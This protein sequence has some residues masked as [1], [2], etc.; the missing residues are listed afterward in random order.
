M[1]VTCSLLHISS[2]PQK[3]FSTKILSVGDIDIN[4]KLDKTLTGKTQYLPYS[5]SFI[6]G[7][8]C[9]CHRVYVS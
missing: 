5:T 8:R 7:N 4:I 1:C 9:I 2:A 3:R 6:A